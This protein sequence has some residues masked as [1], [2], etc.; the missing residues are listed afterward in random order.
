MKRKSVWVLVGLVT[1]AILACGE[2]VPQ[3]TNT[4]EPGSSGAEQTSPPEPT[5][6]TVPEPTSVPTDTPVPK[7]STAPTETP[8]PDPAATPKSASAPA[9]EPTV[10][11]MPVATLA[12]S[13]PPVP[14][15]TGTP[16]PSP[17]PTAIPE[18]QPELPIAGTLAPLGDSLRFV[19]YLNRTTQKWAIYDADGN[20]TPEDLPLPP[21]LE[22]PDASEIVSLTELVSG[23]IYN[24]VV[25]ENQTAEFNG[26]SMTLYKGSNYLQ[27][28]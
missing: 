3:S 1:A 13:S 18:M 20:F 26:D 8:V 21:E 5:Y 19:A 14:E 24:F 23:Q 9:V 27:W 22:V 15:P 11:L 12:P 16:I 10:T 7:L 2:A 4:K 6:T 28:E 25:N 17:E